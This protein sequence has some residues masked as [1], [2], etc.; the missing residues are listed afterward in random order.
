MEENG[1]NEQTNVQTQAMEGA[2]S[3]QTALDT[4]AQTQTVTPPEENAQAG[5]MD[6]V[7]NTEA[8]QGEQ[9]PP[10]PDV[11]EKYEFHTPEG[12]APLTEG[13]I[14]AYTEVCR[15]MGLTQEQAQ[16]LYEKAAPQISAMYTQ[17]AQDVMR[18]AQA[19]WQSTLMADEE[20]GGQNLENTKLNTGKFLK[21]FGT[22][23]FNTLMKNTGLMNH[24]ELVRVMARVGAAMGNDNVFINGNSKPTPKRNPLEFMYD[25]SPELK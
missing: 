12:Q 24:P 1:A 6:D 19:K 11:P 17:K 10:K 2:A 15:G 18:Q 13:E 23:G 22:Q 3:E 4:Q 25:H 14:Q 16:M 9:E 20:L 5:V 21:A 7:F 8:Q